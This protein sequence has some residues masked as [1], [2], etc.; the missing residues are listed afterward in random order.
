MVH[1]K[2]IEHCLPIVIGTYNHSAP[3]CADVI[4]DFFKNEVKA[5][6]G[7]VFYSG[8][9]SLPNISVTR[10]ISKVHLSIG[11]SHDL[12]VLADMSSKLRRIGGLALEDLQGCS[13]DEVYKIISISN[14]S[15]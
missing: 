9:N 12:V 1:S 13:D 2:T 4:A 5:A 11:L 14:K 6:D 3:S 15:V 7:Y 10:I 8:I